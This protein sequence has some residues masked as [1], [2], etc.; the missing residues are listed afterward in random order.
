M[1]QD[2]SSTKITRHIL[3]LC[4]KDVRTNATVIVLQLKLRIKR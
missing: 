4:K 1:Q 2:V 3:K